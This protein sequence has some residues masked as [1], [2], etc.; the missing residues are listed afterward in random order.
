MV[1][2]FYGTEVEIWAGFGPV[3]NTENIFLADYE[4]LLRAVFSCFH[5][6]KNYFFLNVAASVLKRII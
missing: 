1:S 4:E 5:G 3:G 6:Q 2:N